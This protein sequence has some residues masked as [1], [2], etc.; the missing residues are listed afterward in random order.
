[1][2][3]E[4]PMK[5][6]TGKQQFKVRMISRNEKNTKDKTTGKQRCYMGSSLG[7]QKI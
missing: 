2:L 6:Q 5:L 3:Q 1:M 4:V 7:R